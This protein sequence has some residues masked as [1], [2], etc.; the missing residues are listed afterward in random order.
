MSPSELFVVSQI[1]M[2]TEGILFKKKKKHS[3]I[4]LNTPRIL[5]LLFHLLTALCGIIIIQSPL[6]GGR[7]AMATG[8]LLDDLP[9][10]FTIF[11]GFIVSE[12]DSRRRLA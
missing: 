6:T 12:T 2:R 7:V 9:P 11:I 8:S 4:N 5:L 10:P 1:R 3:S